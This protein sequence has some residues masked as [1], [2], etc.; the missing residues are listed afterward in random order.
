MPH[1]LSERRTQSF[2]SILPDSRFRQNDDQVNSAKAAMA[3]P[4]HLLPPSLCQELHHHHCHHH[5]YHHHNGN[6]NHNTHTHTGAVDSHHSNASALTLMNSKRPAPEER[7][8][9]T[10][11]SGGIAPPPLPPPPL[12]AIFRADNSD[13]VQRLGLRRSHAP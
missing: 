6:L 10:Q 2:S 1:R 5:H 7:A 12:P 8:L 11:H 13:F 4:R 3:S 9:G